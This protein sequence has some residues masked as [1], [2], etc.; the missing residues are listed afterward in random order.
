MEDRGAGN[1]YGATANIPLPPR[2]GDQAF[3]TAMEELMIP[4]LER[5]QPQMILVSIGFDAH[6]RD[7]L[8][9]LFLSAKTQGILISRLKEWAAKHCDGKIALF[10][11]GGY[12]LEAGAAC[13]Q[14]SVSALIGEDWQDPLG[15]S[16]DEEGKVWLP[17]I[18]QARALWGL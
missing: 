10:L 18:R 13:A 16:P 12:D 14:A 3:L 1:G 5:Y 17:V 4:L 9:Y 15:P 2:S 11:E 6:W 8:G 7:P